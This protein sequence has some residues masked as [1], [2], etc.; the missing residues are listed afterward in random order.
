[1]TIKNNKK[2]AI[3]SDHGGFEMKEILKKYLIEHNISVIDCG[4]E[5][6]E[7]VDYP[8][9]AH[10]VAN[11]VSD[12]TVDIGIIVDGAGIGS[13]MVA[14]KIEGVRAALCYDLSTAHN[15]REHNNA[16]V[17]TLGAGL[18]AP[19]LAKQIVETF[20]S[21]HCTADR[22]LRRVQMIKNLA[23]QRNVIGCSAVRTKSC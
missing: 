13:A 10:A 22:H 23:H 17:L 1:M 16:N 8:K 4:T 3:G 20:L 12:G 9:F 7:P 19:G 11:K 21:H 18:V 2:I 15:A 5:S 6:K 14:N